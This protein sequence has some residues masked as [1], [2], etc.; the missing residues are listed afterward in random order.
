MRLLKRKGYT[1]ISLEE[2]FNSLYHTKPLPKKPICITFDDGYKDGYL[3][4]FKLLKSLG[5]KGTYFVITNR[6]NKKNYLT[7]NELTQMKRKGMEI[8]SHSASHIDLIKTSPGKVWWEIASSKSV[9]EKKLQ[10]PI[11]FFCHPFGH[12]NS[13]TEFLL[14][15]AG[16]LLA[17]T[18][19]SGRI[20]KSSH[21]YRIPRIRIRRS[22]TLKQFEALIE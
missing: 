6:L 12:F 1:T 3:N 20:A 8:G 22:T 14:K 15:K 2:L 4:A 5:L 19:E 9:L 18:K 10:E 17:T 21:P 7:W 16:Y 13:K 11:Y